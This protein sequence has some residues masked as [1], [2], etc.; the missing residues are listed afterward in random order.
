M[1]GDEKQRLAARPTQNPE[2]YQLYLKGRYHAE[3]FSKEEL[4]RGLE[5]IRQAIAIDPKFAL[6]Y[7]GL[8]D[9]YGRVDDFLL[10]PREAMPKAKEAAKKALEIDDTLAAAHTE[11]ANIYFWYDWDWP[12]AE[13]EYRRAIELD[14]NYLRAHEFYGWYLVSMGRAAEGIAEAKR[15]AQLD[16]LSSE[17]NFVLGYDLYLARRY[18]EAIDQL[19]KTLELD[20]NYWPA[21]SLPSSQSTRISTAFGPMR[22]SPICC[23]ARDCRHNAVRRSS[24]ARRSS[25][26]KV[27][28]IDSG[29]LESSGKIFVA[30]P[31]H[32]HGAVRWVPLREFQQ[33]C[34]I[35]TLES[36]GLDLDRQGAPT[37]FDH[38]IN[39]EWLFA[40]VGD[41]LPLIDR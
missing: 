2:A 40:P 26:E 23:G 13:R 33:A 29:D 8:A 36:S 35:S 38:A 41:S 39:L 20:S 16:P 18:E 28:P 14:P 9:Y 5:Y 6:A 22:G 19:R 15:A 17:A 24:G 25:T 37:A 3:K 32:D 12:A 27:N 7:T 4:E 21:Q 1:S 11:M 34:E 10:A 30:G 31:R